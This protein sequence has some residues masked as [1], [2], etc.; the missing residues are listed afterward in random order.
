MNR[1][2]IAYATRH[3]Q[4]KKV[5]SYVGRELEAWGWKAHVVNVAQSPD[6]EWDE[7]DAAILVASVYGG[8]HEKEMIAF[9]RG[10]REVLERMPNAFLSVALSTATAADPVVPEDLRRK[11]S[12]AVQQI[13]EKFVEETGWR[14]Q[15]ALPVAGALLYRHYNFLMRYIMKRIARQMNGP[16]APSDT[17]QDYEYTDWAALTHFAINF[18]TSLRHKQSA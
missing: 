5:A 4:S 18:S 11:A 15:Q 7:C 9:V 10:H 17:S 13:I 16:T 14:P 12:Q 1:I 8:H 2:L 3:G 6:V